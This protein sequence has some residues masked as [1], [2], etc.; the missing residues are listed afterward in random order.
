MP[1][2]LW[3]SKAAARGRVDLLREEHHERGQ[4]IIGGTPHLSTLTEPPTGARFL[5][6][7][8]PLIPRN[9]TG[10]RAYTGFWF[11][12]YSNPHRCSSGVG[13]DDERVHLGDQPVLD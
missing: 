8:S 9:S 6:S 2:R 5:G 3:P 12:C 11:R 4:R 1:S 13:A 10:S 7:A